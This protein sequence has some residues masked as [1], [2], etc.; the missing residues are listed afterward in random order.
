MR[1]SFFG[2]KGNK[3][4]SNTSDAATR[5]N[6][7]S[8]PEENVGIDPEAVFVPKSSYEDAETESIKDKRGAMARAGSRFLRF[9]QSGANSLGQEG[10]AAASAATS[11]L[12]ESKQSPAQNRARPPAHSRQ[13]S[14]DAGRILKDNGGQRS[15]SPSHMQTGEANFSDSDENSRVRDDADG[16]RSFSRA[17][18]TPSTDHAAHNSFASPTPG[19]KQIVGLMLGACSQLTLIAKTQDEKNPLTFRNEAE[20]S[21]GSLKQGQPVSLAIFK[22]PQLIAIKQSANQPSHPENQSDQLADTPKPHRGTSPDQDAQAMPC[23]V[24]VRNASLKFTL[25]SQ[26]TLKATTQNTPERPQAAPLVQDGVSSP[27]Q[28]GKIASLDAAGQVVGLIPNVHS[29]MTLMTKIQ[30][31]NNPSL[32]GNGTESSGR[33]TEDRATSSN[34]EAEAR[35]QHKVTSSDRADE[36]VPGDNAHGS[37]TELPRIDPAS[38]EDVGFLDQRD[39]KDVP[40]DTSGQFDEKKRYPLDRESE[41]ST[42]TAVQDKATSPAHEHKAIPSNANRL[43]QEDRI[44]VLMGPT[45]AGKSTFINYATKQ[46]GSTVGHSLS[47]ETSEIRAVRYLHPDDNRPVIFVDT[48]GFD[49]THRSDIEILSQIAGWFVK[50]YKEHV[51][52]AAIVYLHR[53]SDNR[54]AGSPLKNLKMFA[55]MCG[56]EAMPRVVLGTT[57]WTEVAEGTGDRRESELEKTFW[58]DMIKQGC[59]MARFQDTFESAWDMVGTLATQEHAMISHEIVEDRKRL[60]ETA[61]GLKLTEE[62]ARLIADQKE[63]ARQLE[64]QVGKYNNPVLVEE[65]QKRKSEIEKRVAIVAEQIHRLRIPWRRKLTNWFSAN[66]KARNAGVTYVLLP[67]ALHQA[68]S[69][70]SASSI[71]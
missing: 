46:G 35:V 42:G 60:N 5:S 52:L 33:A 67:N 58:A 20:P 6:S 3:S 19:D 7:P 69:F 24:T 62:L 8:P 53:I 41:P 26:L 12:D 66:R 56:Q 32:L 59:R 13:N 40:S 15:A 51:P 70:I 71:V 22:R 47:S 11:Q 29:L 38:K 31:A 18:T 36:V 37:G 39:S 55:S 17:H 27:D 61:A 10:K 21:A 50:I 43:S 28:G 44:V 23:D 25:Y 34:Q 2:V 9:G 65:L 49:D 63:A 16:K 30:D 14:G 64:E 1:R 57:M 48:P 54:M 4:R 68:K 45:G